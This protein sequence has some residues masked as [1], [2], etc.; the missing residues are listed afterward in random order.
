ML[1][2][3]PLASNDSGSGAVDDI[4][5]SALNVRDRRQLEW[6]KL[7]LQCDDISGSIGNQT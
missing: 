3:L 5:E 1:V 4:E 7:C 2:D 6:R